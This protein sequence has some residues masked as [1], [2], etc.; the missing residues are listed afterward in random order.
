MEPASVFMPAFVGGREELHMRMS[1]GLFDS[2]VSVV[3]GQLLPCSEKME[4]FRFRLFMNVCICLLCMSW[5]AS[6]PTI[7]L[8]PFVWRDWMSS[9]RSSSSNLLGSLSGGMCLLCCSYVVVHPPDEDRHGLYT[10]MKVVWIYSR[11][12]SVSMHIAPVSLNLCPI[13]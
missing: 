5:L 4:F 13:L 1:M 6:M 9:V 12:R 11:P 8:S 2:P 7:I 10:D 3:D